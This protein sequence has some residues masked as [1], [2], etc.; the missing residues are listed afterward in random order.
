MSNLEVSGITIDV[1][2]FGTQ[3]G[4]PN[5]GRVPGSILLQGPPGKSAYQVAV[6]QGFEGSEAEWLETL[7]AKPKW[8]S[9][10]W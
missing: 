10:N 7:K 3:P 6:E 4:T 5:P 2:D 8:S 9:T 1:A